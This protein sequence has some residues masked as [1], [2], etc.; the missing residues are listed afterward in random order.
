MLTGE[1]D[2][3]DVFVGVVFDVD[4]HFDGLTVVVN[5]EKVKENMSS[6]YK[7]QLK[8]TFLFHSSE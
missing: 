4:V 1:D 7:Y 5:L 3:L 2:V 6:F 8:Q